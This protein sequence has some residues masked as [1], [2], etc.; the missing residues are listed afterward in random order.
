MSEEKF[1]IPGHCVATVLLAASV[2]VVPSDAKAAILY[3]T[4]G[5]DNVSVS[6][7]GYV[8]KYTTTGTQSTL[9][10]GMKATWGIAFDSHGNLFVASEDQNI[11][12]YT[13]SGSRSTFAT[14]LF[15]PH[16]LTFD[17]AGNLFEADSASGNIYKFT[18]AG[19][20]STFASGLV[21]P[22]AVAFDAIGNAFV[23][24]DVN[25]LSGVIYKYSPDGSR[26]TFA[27]GLADPAGLAFNA[28]G[29]LFVG[30]GATIQQI[31]AS[32]SKSTYA[33]ALT[34]AGGLAFDASGNLFVA[35]FGLQT[36]YKYTP[37][38][39][40]SVFASA[41]FPRYLAFAPNVVPEPGSIAMAVVGAAGLLVWRRLRR[42][43]IA[44]RLSSIS[45]E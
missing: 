45:K 40:Q 4:G 38:R 6:N 35:D 39:S 16:G 13:P 17:A 34:G 42:A 14:G 11:Y 20:R 23:A 27:T 37:T 22:Y 5:D 31:T 29:N 26:S 28:S 7:A 9:D 32:G 1:R 30:D 8:Y 19:V 10:S 15:N 18:P 41:P 21:L 43:E 44:T 12:K 24:D 25:Y 3:L 2:L 33:T 36:I